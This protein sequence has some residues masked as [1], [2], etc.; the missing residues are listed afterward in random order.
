VKREI[1]GIVIAI[2]S[3]GSGLLMVLYPE[4]FRDAQVAWWQSQRGIWAFRILGSGLIV[5]ALWGADR[6]LNP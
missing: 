5:L 1:I 3:F 4:R 6:M 2:M